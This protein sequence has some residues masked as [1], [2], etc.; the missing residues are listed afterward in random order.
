MGKRP[1]PA[2]KTVSDRE[3]GCSFAVG[4]S[5]KKGQRVPQ[6]PREEWASEIE[7][8]QAEEREWWGRELVSAEL[9]VELPFWLMVPDGEISLTY[10]K[11]KV[12]ASIRGRYLEVSDGP[13]S[14]SSR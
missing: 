4:F 3:I 8:M 10:E 12:V 6:I 5:P 14:L 2:T 13:M 7:L 9:A 11:T 1:T